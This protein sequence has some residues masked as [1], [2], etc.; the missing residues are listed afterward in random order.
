MMLRKGR[1]KYIHYTHHGAELYDLVDDPEELHSL[2]RNP[3]YADILASFERDLR[4]LVA[5]EKTDARA[6]KV[7]R[8]RLAELGGMDKIVAQGGVTHTP[9]P[10]EE[11]SVI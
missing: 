6:K 2:A 4:V 8:A 1:F 5:P 3:E 11:A 10:G 9:P 7:Q